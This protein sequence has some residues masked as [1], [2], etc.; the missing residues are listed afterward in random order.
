[1]YIFLILFEL[2]FILIPVYAERKN[3]LDKSTLLFSLGYVR[4][5]Y[6]GIHNDNRIELSKKKYLKV[7]RNSQCI[8]GL[9]L[10]IITGIMYLCKVD[11]FLASVIILPIGFI[12]CMITWR[13]L[14]KYK[15]CNQ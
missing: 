11:E 1:M 3:S 8:L 15:T 9:I 5:D 2:M 10:I 14:K 13:N 7:S 4:L 12:G 6:N